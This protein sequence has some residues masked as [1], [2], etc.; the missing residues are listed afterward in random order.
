MGKTPLRGTALADAPVYDI[1]EEYQ[2]VQS[3]SEY[4]YR[5]TAGDYLVDRVAQA[6]SAVLSGTTALN[7]FEIRD[8]G[9]DGTLAGNILSHQLNYYDGAAFNGLPFG[10][11]GA[12]GLMVK[13]E[14]LAVTEMEL[15][16]AYGT[17]IP[18]PF[19]AGA[20]PN[21]NGYP[22]SFVND[23]SDTKLGYTHYGG[24]STHLKGYYAIGQKLKYD[25]QDSSGKG[26]VTAMQDLYDR[27]TKITYDAYG[28]LPTSVT[29]PIGLSVSSVNDYRVLAPIA[30]ADPNK[31][32]SKVAYNAL[33]LVEKTALCG[34]DTGAEGDTLS[35]PGAAFTYNFFAFLNDADPISV[36]KTVREHHI[37]ASYLSSLPAAER[38]N[39]IQ[40]AEYSDGYGRI[41]QSRAQAE[42]IIYGDQT[43]GDSG[44][45]ADQSQ[46]GPAVGVARSGAAPLNVVVSG[47]KRYNN[48][49][50]IVEQFEPYFDSGFDYAEDYA[51]A[52]VS[53]KIYYD[54]LGRMVKTVNPDGSEQRVVFGIPNALNTHGIYTPTSWERYMYDAND[55]AG[56][57][58]PGGPVPTSHHYTPKSEK[59]DTLG[60]V[61]ESTEHKAHYNGSAYEDVV[62][63]YVYDIKGQLLQ[64]IDPYD[65]VISE[66]RYDTAGNMLSS[67]H[68]D[69]G[70]QNI[71]LDAMG[72]PTIS[73]DAKGARTLNSYDALNRPTK[74]YA[75]DKSGEATALRMVNSYGDSAGLSSPENQNLKGALYEQ[76]DGAGRIRFT[77]YDFKGN[78]L[79]KNRRVLNDTLITAKSKMVVDWNSLSSSNFATTGYDTD[80]AYDGLNRVR[81]ITYPNDK[82]NQRKTAVPKYNRGGALQSMK[83]NNTDYIKEIA[84]NARGQRILVAS[85]SLMQRYAYD[86]QTFRLVRT[87]ARKYTKSGN[88]YT[89]AAGI[90]LDRG[91]E[92]DLMGSVVEER[93]RTP[94][95]TASQG[96]GS[97]DRVF[98]HDPMRRLL[99]ATGRES[100]V[101][102]VQ[103]S[104]DLNVRPQDYTA[105]NTY[106][107]SYAYD[108]LG[109]IQALRHVA[110]GIPANNFNRN[111]NYPS[112]F[113]SNMLE[114]MG[115][116]ASTYQYTYDANGN[117]TKENTDRYFDWNYADKLS[118]YKRQAGTGN[119]SV[120]VHYFYDGQ[121]NRLKKVVNKP[122]G[123][124]EMTVYIDGVFEH[125]YVRI[126]NNVDNNRNYNTLHILDGGS[127][128]ATLRVGNDS[129]DSTP[130]LKYYVEDHLGNSSVAVQS[131]GNRI[132]LEEYYPFGETSYGSFA[133]KRYR[134]NGKEKDEHTGLYEYG[135]RYYAPWLCRFVSVDPI[136]E[137]YPQL[138]S[139]NYAGNKPVTSPDIEGLQGTEDSKQ[140]AQAPS[141]G[142]AEFDRQANS[143]IETYGTVDGFQV[144]IIHNIDSQGNLES[145]SISVSGP[146]G[147]SKVLNYSDESGFSDGNAN[148]PDIGGQSSISVYDSELRNSYIKNAESNA[149]SNLN[150]FDRVVTNS[151]RTAIVKKSVSDRNQLKSAVRKNLT[152]GASKITEALENDSKYTP[153]KL[154]KAYGV[155]GEKKTNL[156]GRA[157]ER[158][159]VKASGRTNSL[160]KGLSKAGRVLGWAGLILGVIMSSI[161]IYNDPT[162]ANIGEE[163]GGF[164]FG[165]V[166]ATVGTALFVGAALALGVA[167][168]GLGLIAI[169]LIG[170]AIGG[171]AGSIAGEKAGRNVGGSMS[172]NKLKL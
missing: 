19:S 133:K 112:G 100:T 49:G 153:E 129:Q 90:R 107:R 95:S 40:S 114:S 22:T 158:E 67:T 89:P 162:S 5:D 123:I 56:E 160:L 27:E 37:N 78:P 104:W 62:M 138:C 16:T 14:Q 130:A 79:Q 58:H 117:Q 167:T 94:A 68:I 20:N 169:G 32:V 64:A 53:L 6:R 151:E 25:V 29:D 102:L 66:N 170:G 23:L 21:W 135:Q 91:Y 59:I 122:G 127:R 157:L 165:A 141:S 134:Y 109:N 136:A 128:I 113:G 47:H 139:Y 86:P 63:K 35:T 97:I 33:G 145:G 142:N 96:P 65:R 10:Q 148:L 4:I 87:E 137:D 71:T 55:L 57:T 9:F 17:E 85:G 7:V 83:F 149:K 120:W 36:L 125:T 26:L 163:T 74:M 132:N 39:T 92:H 115:I 111:Y 101:A 110:N 146:N 45:P 72:L 11:L 126:N 43:F 1:L 98:G 77:A 119:P 155:G 61:K 42:D 46:N 34:K 171:F 166:G 75:R 106:T 168:G 150:A 60:R 161:D 31:N 2:V 48:K 81:S 8:A 108:K 12:Y 54:A 103:P 76:Y 99:S 116:G 70:A 18:P 140:S 172:P 118:F 131:N 50:E 88:T 152:P 154:S 13:S 69:R 143:A 156:A 105:T 3:I 30:M 80:M 144:D 41:V 82:A 24:T 28:L 147:E 84:Y 38:N 164:V 52:G 73:N 51:T 93:D 121:G 159:I 124:Q 44:L 15:T